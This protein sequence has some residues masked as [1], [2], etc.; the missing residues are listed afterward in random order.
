MRE[1][2]LVEL[3]RF[4]TQ[5]SALRE[6]ESTRH[7]P[8]PEAV[9]SPEHKDHS[10]KRPFDIVLV[11]V[12]LILS[13][14]LWVLVTLAILIHG[15]GSVFYRQ[16]RWGRDGKKFT[17]YKFRTMVAHSDREY[18]LTQA[19]EDD[20]RITPIGRVL[21]KTGIDELPQFINI[22]KGDMSF[23]GP[24]ALAIGET[25]PANGQGPTPYENLK[26]FK[27][28]LVVRPGLTGT[29][30]V[31]LPRDAHPAKKFERDLQYIDQQA[32]WLDIKLI[33]LSLW[34]SVRGK[35]ESREKKF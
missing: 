8:R 20:R 11:I 12:G 14:P 30:T 7:A 26:S 17:L 34:I 5:E 23:V 1:F 10:F 9:A 27:Q 31:Y 2:L 18:G 25:L 16:E 29:A 13:S 28:R 4:A 32:F 24:R 35:W 22:L 19:V 6:A 3:H 15:D 33:T 21:R